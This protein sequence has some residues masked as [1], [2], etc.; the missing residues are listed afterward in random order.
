MVCALGDEE[1]HGDKLT[2]PAGTR[3]D[4]S[5]VATGDQLRLSRMWI[6]SVE[7]WL[8]KVLEV[9]ITLKT[10]LVVPSVHSEKYPAGMP[11]GVTDS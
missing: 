11:Y 1:K 8:R 4:S 10:C 9:D 3:L 6:W 2:T 5:N 7:Q